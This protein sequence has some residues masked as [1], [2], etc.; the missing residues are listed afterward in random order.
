MGSEPCHGPIL[1]CWATIRLLYGDKSDLNITRKLGNLAIQ[2][3]VF[4][5]LFNLLNTEPF[6]G[7]TTVSIKQ[8]V[9]GK[10]LLILK[11]FDKVYSIKMY[12][13]GMKGSLS[14]E[15]FFQYVSYYHYAKLSKKWFLVV[16]I[17]LKSLPTFPHT[18]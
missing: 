13:G 4:D 2:L 17:F 5:V 7:K 18:F 9:P 16:G 3:R 8:D 6:N 12:V 14:I 10:V 11:F 1:L 15:C